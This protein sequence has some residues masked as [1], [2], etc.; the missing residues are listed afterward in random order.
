[1]INPIPTEL[2]HVNET[3]NAA[4]WGRM[5]TASLLLLVLAKA[6]ATAF[7]LGSGGSGGVFAP[8]LFMGACLG[9]FWGSV[10]NDLFPQWTASPGSYALVGMG[11]M[12]SATTHAPITAILIIFEL[13]NDYRII[14]PLMLACVIGVLLSG[15]LHRESIYTAKLARR[16]VRLSEGRDVSL[17]R[18][19]RVRNHGPGTHHGIVQSPVLGI[20][21]ERV[22]LSEDEVIDLIAFLQR[23]SLL[24]PGREKYWEA[25]TLGE[26]T[27]ALAFDEA[28]RSFLQWA[29][30]TRDE[31]CKVTGG[32]QD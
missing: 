11:A 20:G 26:K 2:A 21:A 31:I 28:V 24:G 1:M 6:V 23:D 17:L 19:L 27:F 12:V 25:Y 10:V 29:G 30:E 13:T 7:T 22:E 18:G 14:P 15:L 8:S 4:L 32:K 5:A 3:I 16:G 9:S